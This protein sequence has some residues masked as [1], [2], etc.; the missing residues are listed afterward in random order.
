MANEVIF[1]YNYRELIDNVYKNL[2]RRMFQ[3]IEKQKTLKYINLVIVILLEM[4]IFSACQKTAGDKIAAF[5]DSVKSDTLK[6]VDVTDFDWDEV[7]IAYPSRH[8]S[9]LIMMRDKGINFGNI[10][11]NGDF[12]RTRWSEYL[13]VMVFIKNRRIIHHC[14][15]PV[16][17]PTDIDWHSRFDFI[18]PKEMQ[19]MT[20]PKDKAIF[21]IIHNHDIYWIYDNY[22][23]KYGK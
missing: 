5:L 13:E 18:L 14:F 4:F 3:K 7:W 8:D 10:R 20:I 15:T 2:Q 9:C 1:W 6:L 23:F 11:T 16:V 21:K 22:R 17:N 19:L 12:R